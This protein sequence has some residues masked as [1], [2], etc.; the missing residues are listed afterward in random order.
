MLRDIRNQL[1]TPKELKGCHVATYLTYFVEG[2][3]APIALR[4]LAVERPAARG[5]AT[6]PIVNSE[7][8]ENPLLYEKSVLLF[9]SEGNSH[10]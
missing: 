10:P 5:I 8:A 1:G 9:D 4:K 2:H 7:R 3:V 6:A